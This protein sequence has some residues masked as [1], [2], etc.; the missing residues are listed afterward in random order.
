MREIVLQAQ[1][2]TVL[3][4]SAFATFS[5][6]N[7]NSPAF[8]PSLQDGFLGVVLK[9]AGDDVF[10]I[11]LARKNPAASCLLARYESDESVISDWRFAAKRLNLPLLMLNPAGELEL[12]EAAQIHSSRIRRL[13]SPLSGRRPRFL[14]RRKEG[15]PNL[16]AIVHGS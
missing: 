11:I 13:G 4:T 9:S 7:D 12:M 16:M 15:Q 14:S 6:I 2:R 10:E 8:N 5:G 3:E 1:E